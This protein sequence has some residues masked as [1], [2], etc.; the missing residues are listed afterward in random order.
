MPDRDLIRELTVALNRANDE[1][2]A[3]RSALIRV[4]EHASPHL[5]AEA[6]QAIAAELAKVR[7]ALVPIPIPGAT[8]R[9]D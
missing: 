7:P 9:K 1:L 2:T 4:L 5:P 3:H 8:M 6:L